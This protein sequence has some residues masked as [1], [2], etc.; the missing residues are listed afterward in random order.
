M[1]LWRAEIWR[2]HIGIWGETNKK[3]RKKILRRSGFVITKLDMLRM[4]RFVCKVY[5]LCQ[6]TQGVWKMKANKLMRF[7]NVYVVGSGWYVPEGRESAKEIGQRQG[8]DGEMVGSSLGVFSKAK[9]EEDEDTLTLAWEATNKIVEGWEEKIGSVY[10][11]S[12]SHPYA[13]KPTATMLG[14]V[15]GLGEGYMAA[16]LEFACKAGTAGVQIVAAQVEAGLVEVGL[17]VGADVSQAKPG[18]VL[19]FTAGAG[20]GAVILGADKTKA[21]ARL[22][23]SMS[24]SSDT[25]DF[26][27]KPFQKYP[28][29]AGRFSG[30]PGYFAHVEGAAT[31]FLEYLGMDFADFSYVVLH[32]PNKKFPMRAAKRL[33]I[34]EKQLSLGMMV[35]K[36]GNPYSASS[37]V[38]MCRVLE[39]I[40]SG[41]KLLVVSYGSGSGSD[42]LYFGGGIK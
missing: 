33:G 35:E 31:S 19:E 27:R 42:C 38:G 22:V 7:E 8:V 34:T 1:E 9:A 14:E 36:I 37:M 12:E 15:L 26:W 29:H 20:A 18:D 11:G 24:L 5:K 13:V 40:R 41:E 23:A 32:M 3:K 10:V 17:A 2:E 25:N 28:G 39:E 6:L 16:D 21:R 30:G 4:T